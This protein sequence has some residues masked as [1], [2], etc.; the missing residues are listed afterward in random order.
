MATVPGWTDLGRCDA[1]QGFIKETE[2][3]NIV[4]HQ[5][6]CPKKGQAP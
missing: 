2:S 4:G 3:G 6:N 5:D 1:C